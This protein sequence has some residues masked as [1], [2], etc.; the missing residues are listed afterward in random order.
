MDA[1]SFSSPTFNT[2]AWV[3][4]ALKERPEEEALEAYLASLAMRLHILSQDYTDQLETGM[5]EAMST[6]PRVLS[7]V[8]RIE[9]TLHGVENEMQSL[10]EQIRMF[11]QRN[12]AGV[13]DLSRLDTL[14]NNMGKCKA[15]LEEHARWSQ[16]VREAT[17][18]LEGGGRLSDSADRIEVMFRSLEILKNMPGHEERKETCETLSNSLL[19]ALR[20]R[21]R[22]DVA[23]AD[24]SPL[25][26]YLYAYEKLG[27]KHELESE[28]VQ[29][30]PAKI[31]A[32]WE[33]Y[34]SNNS[35]ATGA[36]FPQWL[37]NFLGKVAHLLADEATNTES[38][39]G[40]DRAP[41]VLSMILEET[42]QPLSNSMAERLLATKAPDV[43]VQAYSVMEEFVRRVIGYLEGAGQQR[44]QNALAAVYGGFVIYLDHYGEMEG[45]YLRSFFGKCCEGITFDAAL[46]SSSS[47]S[48]S[49]SASASDGFVGM[50][51]LE[52]EQSLRDSQ[53]PA[54]MYESYGKR[55]VLAAD[56]L[57]TPSS[58]VMHRAVSLMG[59]IRVKPT[60]RITATSISHYIK[61]LTAKADELRVACG[62]SPEKSSFNT[63]ARSVIP[64]EA[65]ASAGTATSIAATGPVAE[66]WAKRLEAADMGGR[67]LIPSAL[68][69]LQ[70]SGRMTRRLQEAEKLATELLT[71]IPS[72]LLFREQVLERAIPNALSNQGSVGAIYASFL[73]ASDS[74]TASELRSFLATTTSHTSS[75][76]T[77][78]FS[79]VIGT[80]GR[81][82]ASAGALLFDLCTSV[83]EKMIAHLSDEDV[84]SE[85]ATTSSSSSSRSHHDDV[86]L[87]LSSVTQVGEHMLSLVDEIE[88]FALSDALPD[89]LGLTGEAQS[90][91]VSSRGWRQIK[92][93]LD[94]REEEGIEQLC[95]RSTSTATISSVEKT[96][97]GTSC[98]SMEDI[99]NEA[100]SAT[101]TAT[102]ATATASASITPSS[103]DFDAA[104]LG[105]VN[106]WLGSISDAIIGLI[107]FQ[108]I[109][110]NVLT[111][112]GCAHLVSNIDYLGNVV[113]GM[114]LRQHPL[115]SHIKHVLTRDPTNISSQIN[116]VPTRSAV[117]IALQ[118]LDQRIAKAITA[119]LSSN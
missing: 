19:S 91:A 103:A 3:N 22:R 35:D 4:N 85:A 98:F 92:Q 44:L 40:K 84:W 95:R 79:S 46:S 48:S 74:S 71:S 110:I 89:L 111:T 51:D 87:P 73:L 7:E 58:E 83:P 45:S 37:A 11:D 119:G 67:Q 62:Q 63:V 39:F 94:L 26:E 15:T 76:H 106:E 68:R 30:R 14:K 64:E 107:I 9:E 80:L 50:D 8:S 93:Q 56:E 96:I 108:I 81:F 27:R 114:G 112:K 18:F 41:E 78:V 69:T 25:H 43:C 6:M 1:S 82:K 60:L 42:F 16:L 20:P 99:E 115:L 52:D 5:V 34:S 49:S 57:I 21:V 55:L 102:A 28:Y 72:S 47:S 23:G 86:L 65:S 90:F 101:A 97:F 77:A 12:V 53:N 75:T 88:S 66:N 117:T 104:A 113:S 118:K 54:E 100:A 31:K 10:A 38:L 116:S 33:S 29:A 105:F 70:A 24:L 32:Q 17:T 2:I 36:Q 109:Q 61:Q 59:G 13:E